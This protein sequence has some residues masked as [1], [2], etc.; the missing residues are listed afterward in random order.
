MTQPGGGDSG[1][2]ERGFLFGP[3]AAALTISP[4]AMR[5][6]PRSVTVHLICQRVS[7]AARRPMVECTVTVIPATEFSEDRVDLPKAKG[8]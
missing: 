2:D 4:V 6:R 7:G 3:P 5:A 8:K 1:T